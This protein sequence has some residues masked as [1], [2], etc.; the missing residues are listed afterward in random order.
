MHA[1]CFGPSLGSFRKP[2]ERCSEVLAARSA[3][4]NATDIGRNVPW[5]SQPT[6]PG[7]LGRSFSARTQWN[8]GWMLGGKMLGSFGSQIGSQNVTNVGRNVPWASQPT[9][10]GE[11]GR[12]FSARTR[13]NFGWMLGAPCLQD[14]MENSTLKLMFVYPLSAL[15]TKLHGEHCAQAYD[16]FPFVLLCEFGLLLLTCATPV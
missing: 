5:A 13:W 16:C 11:L 4:Q 1:I 2:L 9:V 7:E 12:N 6:V 8:F 3:P 15:P 14:A 10:P